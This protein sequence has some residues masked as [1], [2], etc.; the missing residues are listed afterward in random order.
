MCYIYNRLIF[1]Y[2]F[3]VSKEG[4]CGDGAGKALTQAP[5]VRATR[6]IEDE[7]NTLQKQLHFKTGSSI[8]SC[9]CRSGGCLCPCPACWGWWLC[10]APGDQ[11]QEPHPP[12]GIFGGCYQKGCSPPSSI[13]AQLGLQG[14]SAG[15]ESL[16]SSRNAS[17]A[18]GVQQKD[19][20]KMRTA[21]AGLRHHSV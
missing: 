18:R 11:T 14:P 9:A 20:K 12:R 8:C 15:E 2:F 3:P 1:F 4:C 17:E 10:T 7:A 13:G 21:N 16:P 6:T 5:W 19:P